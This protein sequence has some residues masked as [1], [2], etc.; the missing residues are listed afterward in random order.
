MIGSNQ[1]GAPPPP[2]V[3]GTDSM[4]QWPISG[5]YSHMVANIKP[6]PQSYDQYGCQYTNNSSYQQQHCNNGNIVENI[7]LENITDLKEIK[8]EDLCYLDNEDF[9]EYVLNDSRS[10]EQIRKTSSPQSQY[11]S[12]TSSPL[13]DLEY[14]SSSPA[15][16]AA[17]SWHS[18]QMVPS[19]SKNHPQYIEER[20]LY[21]DTNKQRCS[22]LAT[23]AAHQSPFYGSSLHHPYQHAQQLPSTR[24][25]EDVYSQQ[26]PISAAPTHLHQFNQHVSTPPLSVAALPPPS[27]EEHVMHY[28]SHT[29]VPHYAHYHSAMYADYD[30]EETNQTVLEEYKNK[31]MER[32]R[33]QGGQI[34]LWQFLL[35]LLDDESNSECI[36]WEGSFGE[37][38]MVNPDEVARKWGEKK[39]KVN[40]TYDK[41]SRALRYYYDKLILTK[42]HGKRYTY[43]FHFKRIVQQLRKPGSGAKRDPSYI[44]HD[45]LPYM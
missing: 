34:Q 4:N 17:D 43:K 44:P 13:S 38:R 30:P 20:P 39:K 11:S 6:E 16:S 32:I 14:Y 2:S 26:R 15:S 31:L 41:L 8:L 27:Y 36:A 28:T 40:M 33:S 3:L 7:I 42:T 5:S 18:D 25:M 29:T 10:L 21:V 22:S 23:P 24:Y 19:V 35:S 12:A 9:S 37:F 45:L 1:P